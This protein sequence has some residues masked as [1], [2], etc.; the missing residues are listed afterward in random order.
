M[1]YAGVT[2]MKVKKIGVKEAN[3]KGRPREEAGSLLATRMPAEWEAG[4]KVM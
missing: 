4:S 3:K 1:G 2:K